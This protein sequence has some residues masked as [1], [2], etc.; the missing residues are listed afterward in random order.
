MTKDKNGFE[1]EIN[2]NQ[3]MNKEMEIIPR[4]LHQKQIDNKICNAS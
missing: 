2:L 3:F 4:T 1:K